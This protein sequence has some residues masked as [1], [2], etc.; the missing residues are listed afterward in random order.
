MNT[1]AECPPELVSLCHHVFFLALSTR[2]RYLVYPATAFWTVLWSQV[3]PTR[4]PGTS[5]RGFEQCQENIAPHQ[6][7]RGYSQPKVPF[8]RSLGG[9]GHFFFHIHIH[10][11]AWLN[12]RARVERTTYVTT[13]RDLASALQ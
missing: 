2:R 6:R 1:T 8:S 5:L 12:V 9:P 4:L 11:S 3:S 10:G 7:E 13:S